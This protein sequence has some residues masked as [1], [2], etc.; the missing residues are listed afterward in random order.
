[1]YNSARTRAYTHESICVQHG[2][3]NVVNLCQKWQKYRE[4]RLE[5]AKIKADLEKEKDGWDALRSLL[6]R[7]GNDAGRSARMRAYVPR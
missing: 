5:I 1:M 6:W 4:K 7:Q 3:I 2:F